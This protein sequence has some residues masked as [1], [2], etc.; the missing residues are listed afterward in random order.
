MSPFAQLAFLGSVCVWGGFR[1]NKI[2]LFS[3]ASVKYSLSF[4]I[5]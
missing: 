1:Q 2:D 4:L 5:P 3:T